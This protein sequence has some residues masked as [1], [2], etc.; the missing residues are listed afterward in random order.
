MGNPFDD[1]FR[2]DFTLGELFYFMFVGALLESFFGD[3]WISMESFGQIGVGHSTMDGAS[4]L[5]NPG[6]HQ[7]LF[8]HR[9]SLVSGR[10]FTRLHAVDLS[11]HRYR[12]DIRTES[13]RRLDRHASGNRNQKLADEGL[14]AGLA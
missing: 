7:N 4:R 5:G 14:A 3:F 8:P 12:R 10:L 9:I 11:D 2:R 13:F 1:P 6:I